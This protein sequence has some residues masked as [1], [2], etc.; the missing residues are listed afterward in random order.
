M[1]RFVRGPAVLLLLAVLSACSSDG[2]EEGSNAGPSGDEVSGSAGEASGSTAFGIPG[3]EANVD[4]TIEIAQF[5]TLAFQPSSIAVAVGE[6][7]MFEVTNEGKAVHE[8]VLGD[9]NLQDEH[10]MEMVDMGG[11]SMGDEPNAITLDPGE[12]ETLVWSFTEAGSFKFGCH[13][14]G[15]YAQGMVGAIQVT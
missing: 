4:R 7:V 3:D 13:E 9:D 12:S 10:E 11:V 1:R 15:H 5:D 14:P 8:F 2:A 6:T